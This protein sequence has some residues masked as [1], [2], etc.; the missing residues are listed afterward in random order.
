MSIVRR[1]GQFMMILTGL[2]IAF[3]ASMGGKAQAYRVDTGLPCFFKDSINITNGGYK[4]E[5]DNY[6]HEEEIYSTGEYGDFNFEIINGSFLEVEPHVRGCI[7]RKKGSCA[8]VCCDPNKQQCGGT[9]AGY[10]KDIETG[11]VTY[12]D[13]YRKEISVVFGEQNCQKYVL[14]P[15]D[16]YDNFTLLSVIKG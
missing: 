6:H 10:F 8:R 4:D 14:E 16:P 2:V 5:K 3:F 13:D 1:R 15:S 7:C 11:E 9:L 12:Q